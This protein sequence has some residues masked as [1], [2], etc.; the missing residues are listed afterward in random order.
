VPHFFQDSFSKGVPPLWVA[1]DL[2]MASHSPYD[3]AVCRAAIAI[4]NI[5]WSLLERGCYD[6]AHVTLKA[7]ARAM[8]SLF[9]DSEEESQRLAE[10]SLRAANLRLAFP[11]RSSS[12]L[13]PTLERQGCPRSLRLDVDELFVVDVSLDFVAIAVHNSA[14][15]YFFQA[16]TEEDSPDVRGELLAKAVAL[17]RLSYSIISDFGDCAPSTYTYALH[18]LDSLLKVLRFLM[19]SAVGSAAPVRAGA[20]EIRTSATLEMEAELLELHGMV[21]RLEGVNQAMF[22]RTIFAAAA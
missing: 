8:I 9:H 3:H 22:G 19:P 14:V 17:L 10:A 12:S 2:S 7:A 1:R 13:A 15:S 21:H 16:I 11:R 5:G 18:I 6:Q 20:D 4:N